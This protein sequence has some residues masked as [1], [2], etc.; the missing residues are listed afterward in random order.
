MAKYASAGSLREGLAGLD[1]DGHPL[2]PVDEVRSD[3]LDGSRELDRLQAGKEL[4]EQDLRLEAGEMG[5]QTEVRTPGSERH[6]IVRRPR[7]IERV[8]VGKDLLVTV[9]AREPRDHLVAPLDLHAAEFYVSRRRSAEVV[10]GR[11]PPEGLLGGARDP[12]RLLLQQL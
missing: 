2:D 9:G 3:P 8:G 7:D 11:G 4:L 12:L 1:A 5:T 10:H 6:V